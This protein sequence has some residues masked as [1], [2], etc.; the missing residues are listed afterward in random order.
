MSL[1]YE[2][3]DKP[4]KVGLFAA[5]AVGCLTA[6]A[7]QRGGRGNAEFTQALVKWP[8]GHLFPTVTVYPIPIFIM[9][10]EWRNVPLCDKKKIYV[11]TIRK[12]SSKDSLLSKILEI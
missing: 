8:S 1:F 3:D 4:T 10:K 7:Q 9:E 11:T 5:K 12:D 6:S 2:S